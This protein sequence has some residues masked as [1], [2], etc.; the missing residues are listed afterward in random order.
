M[1]RGARSDPGSRRPQ[2]HDHPP[3]PLRRALGRDHARGHDLQRGQELPRNPRRHRAARRLDPR[4]GRAGRRQRTR[5]WIPI[6]TEPR[7]HLAPL[8][9]ADQRVGRHLVGQ[10]GSDRSQPPGRRRRGQLAQGHPAQAA[11]AGHLL[12]IQRRARE[13]LQPRA[14]ARVPRAAAA[15]AQT[16]GDGPDRL[17]RHLALARVPQRLRGDRRPAHALGAR[18]RALG[19]RHLH[20]HRRPCPLRP[21]GAQRWLLGRA[22]HPAR[23]LRQSVAHSLAGVRELRV[24]VVAEHRWQAVRERTARQLLRA[25][26]RLQRDLA[27]SGT[28]PGRGHALDRPAAHQ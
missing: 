3:W 4:S 28:G 17:L 1:E 15:G 16:R 20:L 8:P 5:R 9:A 6:S 18:W 26:C 2:R 25:R 19:R 23:R 14:A 11:G 22:A 27:G 10:A 21:D 7:H 24:P 12:R 13:P